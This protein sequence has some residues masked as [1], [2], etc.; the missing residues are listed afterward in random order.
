MHT[1][2]GP[3]V[4]RHHSKQSSVG[5]LHGVAV[6]ADGE[7]SLART[8]RARHRQSGQANQCVLAQ[9]GQV[10]DQLGSI[11]ERRA[12]SGGAASLE[13]LEITGS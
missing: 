10:P 4:P 12:I 8:D 9:K 2:S 6:V 11:L 3:R 7:E 1:Y 5:A 13:V